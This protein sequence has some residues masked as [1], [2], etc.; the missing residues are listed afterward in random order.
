MRITR[1]VIRINTYFCN[2]SY[3][4]LGSKYNYIKA[5]GSVNS[6]Y[7]PDAMNYLVMSIGDSYNYGNNVGYGDI[8]NISKGK[9]ETIYER[10]ISWDGITA[11]G[12]SVKIWSVENGNNALIECVASSYTRTYNYFVLY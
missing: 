4:N 3:Y 1:V 6:F 8:S 2:N 7:A 11:S 10:I 9:I 12:C 5:Y